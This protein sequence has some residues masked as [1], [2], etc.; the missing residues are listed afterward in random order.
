MSRWRTGRRRAGHVGNAQELL[1][2][3]PAALRDWEWHLLNRAYRPALLELRLTGHAGAVVV[4]FQPGITVMAV[5]LADDTVLF[6]DSATG[7]E[8][9]KISVAPPEPHPE[10]TES[11]QSRLAFSPDGRTLAVA[12]EHRLVTLWDVATG[13]LLNTLKGHTKWVLDLEFGRDGRRLATVGADGSARVW[14]A[15]DGRELRVFP[16]TPRDRAAPG[17]ASGRDDHP[18]RPTSRVGRSHRSGA[19]HL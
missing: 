2:A 18:R 16:E 1:A 9:R 12:H 6:L 5:L 13:R 15:R 10:G 11:R 8:I 14:D 4:A 3:C 7:G 17:R 19:A